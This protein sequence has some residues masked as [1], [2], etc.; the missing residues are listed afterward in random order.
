MSAIQT[1]IALQQTR[2]VYSLVA[3][4]SGP[5]GSY[6]NSWHDKYKVRKRPY[7]PVWSQV[8]KVYFSNNMHKKAVF[9][10]I[11]PHCIPPRSQVLRI[12]FVLNRDFFV[13]LRRTTMKP[14]SFFAD[15]RRILKR[16]WI[17]FL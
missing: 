11:S 17:D 10:W 12:F 15:P 5:V 4:P 3:A 13:N 16:M 7:F 8:G 14:R 2:D 6:L 1:G 9:S